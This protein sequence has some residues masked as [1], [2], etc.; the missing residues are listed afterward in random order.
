MRLKPGPK[1]NTWIILIPVALWFIGACAYILRLQEEVQGRYDSLVAAGLSIPFF[2][3]AVAQLRSG[4]LWRNLAAGNRG[5]HR[6]ERPMKFILSTTA[7]FAIGAGIAVCFV[8]QFNTH[9]EQGVAPNRSL[10]PS[11]KS[12]SS[13]RGSED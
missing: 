5:D 3:T 8:H 11:L 4:Y 10:P 12:T 9:G 6:S 1:S 13:V 7:H 2:A